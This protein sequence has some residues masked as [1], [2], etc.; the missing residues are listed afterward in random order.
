MANHPDTFIAG[1]IVGN[2]GASYTPATFNF[3]NSG[4]FD[5]RLIKYATVQSNESGE[6]FI[7]ASGEDKIDKGF[8]VHRPYLESIEG[9]YSFG[10][11]VTGVLDLFMAG[12]MKETSGNMPLFA[13]YPDTFDVYNN[14]NLNTYGI[15]GV[16][17]SGF[18]LVTS[19]IVSSFTG[20]NSGIDLFAQTASVYASSIFNL[21]TRGAQR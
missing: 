1:R 18:N 17:N 21:S 14:M 16:A 2:S 13:K 6:I 15:S 12:K 8:V 4:L 7:E 19:G 5:T 20:V 3:S 10:A 11:R 9:S